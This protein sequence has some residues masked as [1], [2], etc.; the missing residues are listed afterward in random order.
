MSMLLHTAQGR[1]IVELG[2]LADKLQKGCQKCHSPLHLHQCVFE[3]FYGLGS[4]LN[5]MCTC[6]HITHVPTGKRH[7]ASL[8]SKTAKIWDVNTKVASGMLHAGI[9]VRKVNLILSSLN[10][11]SIHH[12]TLKAREREVGIAVEVVA[13]NSCQQAIDIEM[14]CI[15]SKSNDK[16]PNGG[17]IAASFD[18]GWQKRGS[19]H[20]YN[21]LS[22]HA[23]FIGKESGKVLA[24]DVRNKHCRFCQRA[25]TYNLE[26]TPHDCR[27]NWDGSAK[28]MESSMCV[29]ML[30]DLQK[31]G[32][33]V[34]TIIMDNDST[35]IAKARSEVDGS[36]QKVSDF[37][38]TKK[39][40]TNKL[41]SL[42]SSKKYKL[43][44]SKTICHLG[45]CFAY[46]VKQNKENKDIL[47][48]NLKA[49]VPHTFGDH[50]N[51]QEF[52]CGYVRDPELYVPKQLP[53]KRYLVGEELR[54]DLDNIFQKYAEQADKLMLLGS[55]QRNENFNNTVASK[56]PKSLHYSYTTYSIF[57]SG[58]SDI[59]QLSARTG[60][61]T[62]S[63]YVLP[64]KPITEEATR[65]TGLAVKAGHLYKDGVLVESVS[66]KT[67][68][69][70]FAEWL[71]TFP[72]PVLVAHNAKFDGMVLSCALLAIQDSVLS[73]I[74]CGF[75]D[76]LAIFRKEL[77]GRKSYK[78]EC[79]VLDVLGETWNAHDA[80]EDDRLLQKLVLCVKVS[81]EVFICNSTTLASMKDCVVYKRK[82]DNNLPSFT[83]LVERKVISAFMASKIAGSG[84]SVRHIQLAYSRDGSDGIRQ[85]F[86]ELHNGKPRITKC[87]KIVESV[88]RY[89]EGL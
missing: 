64:T 6:K 7:K 4:L 18:G 31:K 39:D 50:A 61:Q 22:G 78:Q 24:Y 26:V 45:K 10:I 51:C 74:I 77:S 62:F 89:L 53:Y 29:S 67:C 63:R 85:L 87:I 70:D 8:D 35:S 86:A 9:G 76:T 41:Y 73:K 33:P 83:I 32:S 46:A 40:F 71:S 25:D 19:G 20:S 5:I 81:D 36:I 68:V 72:S 52:W 43:L 55:S 65:I 11:P 34:Q 79:L 28:A 13:N 17:N 69:T 37:N 30:K 42:Q 66:L 75:S 16:G 44:N 23:T 15:Q 48:S 27:K 12:T 3:Q 59:V 82:K 88:C 60:E 58:L 2:Y 57:L 38:H 14:S 49:I 56:N 54:T 21:S 84:L 80:C 1:R 47:K